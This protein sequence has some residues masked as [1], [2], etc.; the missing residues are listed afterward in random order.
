[1]T[2]VFLE[3]TTLLM[4]PLTCLERWLDK[5]TSCLDFKTAMGSFYFS[6]YEFICLSVLPYACS[7]PSAFCDF[8]ELLELA[9]LLLFLRRLKRSAILRRL[10]NLVL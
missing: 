10:R 6:R 7:G 4:V 1:M 3:V 9:R 2:D 5:V 8:F